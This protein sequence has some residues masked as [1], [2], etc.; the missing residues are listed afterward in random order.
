[1]TYYTKTNI[2]VNERSA[3]RYPFFNNKVHHN[4]TDSEKNINMNTQM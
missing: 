4:I 3:V 2:K 1:M